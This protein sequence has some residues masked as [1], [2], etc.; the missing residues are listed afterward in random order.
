MSRTIFTVVLMGL[1][2]FTTTITSATPTYNKYDKLILMGSH[3]TTINIDL[4]QATHSYDQAS[5]DYSSSICLSV[6]T[7]ASGEIDSIFSELSDLATLYSVMRLISDKILVSRV[8]KIRTN[9]SIK[10]FEVLRPEINSLMG[11][12]SSSSLVQSKGQIILDFITDSTNQ[13]KSMSSV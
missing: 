13:L 5:R 3:A 9:A 4:L 7:N 10:I 12:C 2:I 1:L 6:L 8:I 11:N